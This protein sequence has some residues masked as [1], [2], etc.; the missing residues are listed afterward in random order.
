MPTLI[1]QSLPFRADAVPTEGVSD[2]VDVSAFAVLR[3]RLTASFDA[4]LAPALDVDIQTRRA[5]GAWRVIDSLRIRQA[6][7]SIYRQF[8]FCLVADDE[9]RVKWRGNWAHSLAL[10]QVATFQLTI[11]ATGLPEA[12]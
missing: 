11:E 9:V 6:D 3:C 12:E 4:S 10:H 2:A 8:D 5:D 1:D 7:W